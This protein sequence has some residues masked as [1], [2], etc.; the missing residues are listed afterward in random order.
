MRGWILLD[1]R[2]V[3]IPMPLRY[4]EGSHNAGFVCMFAVKD[5]LTRLGSGIVGNLDESHQFELHLVAHAKILQSHQFLQLDPSHRIYRGA[6]T[7]IFVSAFSF[8]QKV[9]LNDIADN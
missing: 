8:P 1:P 9:V 2:T 7:T 4:S 3:G 6:R 5:G